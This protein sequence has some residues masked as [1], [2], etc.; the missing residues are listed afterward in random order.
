MKNNALQPDEL[1]QADIIQIA[2]E[3]REQTAEPED[4]IR[5]LQHFCNLVDRNKTIPDPLHK[6]LRDSFRIYLAGEQKLESA[7]GLK[8]KRARPKADP[9]IRTVMATELLRLRLIKVSHQDALN[10][11]SEKFGW[12]VSVIGEAWN[13]HKQD[14]LICLRLERTQDASAWTPDEITRLTEIFGKEPWI[15]TPEKSAT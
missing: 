15:L 5:L 4:A 9:K 12:G 7:L 8:R 11:V 6:H 14:A 10:E 3:I 1:T 2:F 13:A